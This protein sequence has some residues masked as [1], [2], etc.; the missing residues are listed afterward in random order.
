MDVIQDGDQFFETLWQMIDEAQTNV[1]ILTYHMVKNEVPNETLRRLISA[2]NRGVSVVLYIDWI[3]Y[4]PDPILIQKL[5]D[6]GGTV[7]A[8]NPMDP[9]SRLKGGQEILTKEVFERYH[10]KVFLI[11]SN[12]IIGSANLD[13]AYAGER[14]GTSQFYDFNVILKGYCVSDVR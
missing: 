2:A 4:W 1:W 10:Q 3:N 14:L 11:D 12:V 5:I 13:N 6:A 8:L 9:I 7:R